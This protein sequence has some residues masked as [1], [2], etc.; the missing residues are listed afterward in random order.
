MQ[1]KQPDGESNY[2]HKQKQSISGESFVQQYEA[3][4]KNGKMAIGFATQ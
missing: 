4:E 3:G 1:A 2:E